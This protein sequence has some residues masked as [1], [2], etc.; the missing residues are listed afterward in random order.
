[1]NANI[2]W[3]SK[4]VAIRSDETELDQARYV[5]NIFSPNNLAYEPIFWECKISL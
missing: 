3:I 2:V 4:L 1:M 5:F